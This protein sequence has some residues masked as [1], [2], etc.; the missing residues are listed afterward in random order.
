MGPK[1][2][3]S[4]MSWVRPEIDEFDIRDFIVHDS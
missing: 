2:R 3:L 4:L 1:N